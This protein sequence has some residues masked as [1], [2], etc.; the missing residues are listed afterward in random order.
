MTDFDFTDRRVVVTGGATGVGAE[1][2]GLLGELGA[3]DVTVLDLHEPS[4]PHATFLPTDLADREAIDYAIERIDGPVDAVFNNAG[5]ADTLPAETVF[6]VNVLAPMRLTAAL[7]PRM[8][9]GG[10]VVVTSSIAGMAWR[11]RLA[12]IE[13][14]LVLDDWDPMIEW[15]D[16]RDLGVGT[17][18]FTKEVMQVW[19]MRSAGALMGRGVRINSVCPSPIDTPL[20]PDFRKTLGDAAIDFTIEHAGGRMVSPREVASVLAFLATP[21]SSFVSGQNLNIDAGFEASLITGTLA[22][23]SASTRDPRP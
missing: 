1:L 13:D 6:R 17:Y 2:L 16:G 3:T 15:F 14:L 4:G 19:T 22:R 7:V 18:A 11:D 23:L 10:A 12:M 9:D 5:V 8:P 21:A 20:A